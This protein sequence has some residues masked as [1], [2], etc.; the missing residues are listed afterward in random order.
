VTTYDGAMKLAAIFF[1]LVCVGCTGSPNYWNP[2][3]PVNAQTKASTRGDAVQRAV[4]ALTDAGREI[5]SSDVETGIVLSKWYSSDGAFTSDT[6]FRVRVVFA[7]SGAYQI[8]ALCQSKASGGDWKDEC[9]EGK[10]PQHVID[11]IAKVDLALRR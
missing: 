11:T 9:T 1:S 5:E 8:D 3:S 4:I 7:E 2:Y 6:R 10:R